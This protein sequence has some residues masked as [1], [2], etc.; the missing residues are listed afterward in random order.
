VLN[1]SK[2]GYSLIVLGS[3]GRGFFNEI[4]IGSVSHQV[5]RQSDVS[6]LLVPSVER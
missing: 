2:N 4:F 6:V 3:Q 1:E 5:A